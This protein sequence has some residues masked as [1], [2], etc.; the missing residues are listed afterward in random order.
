MR[1]HFLYGLVTLQV[2]VFQ[3]LSLRFL[4]S[5]PDHVFGD[6]EMPERVEREILSY[7]RDLSRWCYAIGGGLWGAMTLCAYVLPFTRGATGLLAI[8]AASILSSGFFAWTYLRAR[9]G[10]ER[11][12]EELPDTGLRVASLERRS[13]GKYYNLAWEFVPF[14][15]LAATAV[16]VFWAL[17]RFGQPYPL[18]FDDQG[19][20][21]KWGQGTGR[22]L[23][24]LFVQGLVTF[25][26]LALTFLGLKHP[27]DFSPKAPTASR[28]P[29]RALRR[30]EEARGRTLRF[31]M[32]AKIGLALQ[33]ALTLFVK[34]E[35]ALGVALPNWVD[36]SPWAATLFLLGLFTAYLVRTAAGGREAR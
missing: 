26:L 13:L 32:A 30:S 10:A 24:L 18:S 7:K 17:P 28:D 14:V 6:T 34:V 2:L 12:V 33:V 8:T 4:R 22:F 35:T 27:P 3:F 23:A 5:I 9:S 1:I 15:L 36:K 25:G 19:I 29:E 20:P 31:L 21:D 16:L 11:I